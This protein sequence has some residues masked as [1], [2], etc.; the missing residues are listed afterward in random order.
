MDIYSYWSAVLRQDEEAIREYL[1]PDMKV[2]WMNTNEEF[3]AE[4]FIKVNCIYPGDWNGSVLQ[5]VEKENLIITVTHVFSVSI[6]QSFNV[7]SFII[8]KDDK[9]S[10]LDEYWSSIEE[11]PLWRQELNI[12]G[13]IV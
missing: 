13:P 10:Q 11:I 1:L 5:V 8:I 9:I 7:V 2:R 3:N 6:D 4:E 12:G